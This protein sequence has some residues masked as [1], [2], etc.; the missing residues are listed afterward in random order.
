MIVEAREDV[1]TLSGSL[2]E[3]FWES[4]QTA[5][6][7]SL[8]RHPTGVII[9]CAKITSITEQGA[10]TF[11]SAIDYVLSHGNARIIFAAIPNHVMQVLRSTPHVKSSLATAST[12][13]EARESLT[14]IV[15]DHDPKWKKASEEVKSRNILVVIS[16]DECHDFFLQEIDLLLNTK[17]S[18]L[19][20]LLPV[21]VPRELPLHAPV[22]DE[23]RKMVTFGDKA[24]EAFKKGANLTELRLE[25]T[26]DIPTLVAEMAE[27]VNAEQVIV[28]V[29][30]DLDK[31]N[32]SVK[33]FESLLNKVSRPMM[34]IRAGC[35]E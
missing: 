28:S 34:F 27:E 16:T 14:L 8:R 1:V 19:H 12:I 29:P 11:Q 7:L 18:H 5:I 26:R 30:A 22:P 23:E 35:G 31:T 15:D 24:R 10:Q 9:D 17:P 21:V 33:T 20:F 2:N 32:D 3:A 13:E 6:S 4:I 25:R